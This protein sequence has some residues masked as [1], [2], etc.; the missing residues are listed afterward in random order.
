MNETSNPQPFL[1]ETPIQ[2]IPDILREKVIVEDK[3]FYLQRPA[4]SDKL[5]DH[6]DI[7]EANRVDDYMPY[8]TDIWPASRMMAKA[9]LR[10]SWENF[11]LKTSDKIEALEIGCGL[12][13]AGLAALAKGLRVIFSDYDQTA[14]K[15]VADNAR[16]NGFYDFRTL[17]IDWRHPPQDLKVPV[18]FAADLMYEIRNVEPILNLI[19]QVLLPGGTAFITDQDRTPASILRERMGQMGFK[20]TKELMRAG[21]PGGIR[22][23]G[24]LYRVQ[25]S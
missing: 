19:K 14:L 9:I 16:L 2:A 22:V 1:H 24:T 5:M 18:I 15:F 13:L 21:E 23:K 20:Y 7:R 6:P 12:G 3:V 17:A 25:V 10:E 11:P 4:D 8:W